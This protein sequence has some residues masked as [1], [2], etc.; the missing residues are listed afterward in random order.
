MARKLVKSKDN[1]LT[2][3]QKLEELIPVFARAK[4]TADEYKKTADEQNKKIKSVIKEISDDS[5]TLEI[6]GYRVDFQKQERTSMNEERVLESF[7]T[8]KK[9]KLAKELGIIKTKEYIDYD[10]LENAIYNG[11]LSEKLLVM[12]QDCEEV[13]IV[14]VLKV[15]AIKE[16]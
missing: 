4:A 7:D 9:I 12:L 16:K 1:T 8:C 13:K 2:P 10:A 3:M 11:K 15:S 6:A 14:E 5:Q